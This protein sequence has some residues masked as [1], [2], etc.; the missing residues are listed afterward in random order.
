M[1]PRTPRSPTAGRRRPSTA[2]RSRA[3]SPRTFTLDELRTSFRAVERLPDLRKGSA[4]YDGQ[5]LVPTLE[6]GSSGWRCGSAPSA[7]RPVGVYPET[8]HPVVLPARSGSRSRSRSWRRWRRPA[9]GGPG[10]P[11]F[12]QSFEAGNLRQLDAVTDLPLVQLAYPGGVSADGL[13]YDAL[14][15]PEGLAQVATYADAVG[16]HKGAVLDLDTLRAD[17]AGGRRPRGRSGR[18]RVGRSGRRTP[19]CRRPSAGATTPP[20]TATSRPRSAPS[21][22]PAWTASSRITRTGRSPPSGGSRTRSP[23]PHVAAPG[24]VEHS[25]FEPLTSSMPLTRSTN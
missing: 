22:P 14:L 7:G 18:P 21:P 6:G 23:G 5:F 20:R 17:G 15:T 2:P 13:S 11:V 9:R 24:R 1:S 8:K 10:L 19:F 12:I 4:A 16:V 3:G 25:G